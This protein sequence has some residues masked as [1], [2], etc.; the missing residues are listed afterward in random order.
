ML[1]F[2]NI[3]KVFKNKTVIKDISFTVNKGEFIVIV[4]QSGCGKTTTLKMINRLISPTSGS[5]YVDG[6]NILKE[7]TIKLRRNMGYVIQQTGL[8][9]HM[10]VGENIGIIP[11]LEKWPEDK[12]LARTTELLKMVGMEPKE[13]IDRYPC[14]LSGGQQQRI[15]VAR[16]WA[17]WRCSFDGIRI[18]LFSRGKE[19]PMGDP[20]SRERGIAKLSFPGAPKVS[21]SSSGA[22]NQGSLGSVPE[23]RD[24]H[25]G[26]WE[27][28]SVGVGRRHRS[29]GKR[30]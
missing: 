26:R 30:S 6:K 5:I 7:D 4:G 19:D 15:G 12:I 24:T 27:L 14:E 2:K 28:P 1:E 23:I 11:M 16:A 17:T 22:K 10:T 13:Y 25:P 3:T 21:G 29:N 18:R 8:L 20:V 9:P